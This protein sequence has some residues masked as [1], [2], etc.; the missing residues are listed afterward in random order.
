[1]D[2]VAGVVYGSVGNRPNVDSIGR[3]SCGIVNIIHKY[4]I[5]M[6]VMR[7]TFLA[8]IR[9]GRNPEGQRSVAAHSDQT[10]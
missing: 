2:V 6:Y 8:W 1:M 7:P 10:L 3:A 9:P 5:I 4:T